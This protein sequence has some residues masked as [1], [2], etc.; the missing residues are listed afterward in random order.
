MLKSIKSFLFCHHIYIVIICFLPIMAMTIWHIFDISLPIDDGSGYFFRS[1]SHAQHFFVLEN[2]FF[3]SDGKDS[4]KSQL[5]EYILNVLKEPKFNFLI[6][7]L[8]SF[9]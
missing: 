8:G 2:N 4:K 9:L 7:L 3:E 1:Y 6:T 5:I